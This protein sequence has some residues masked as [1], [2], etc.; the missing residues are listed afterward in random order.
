MAESLENKII[1]LTTSVLENTDLF[2]VDLELK[3]HKGSRTL[4]VYVDS[5]KGGVNLDECAKISEELGFLLDAHDVIAGHY[6][7]NVSSPGLDKPL[8]DKRQYFNKIGRNASITYNV[9]Q[10]QKKVKGEIKDFT[11]DQLLL[12]KKDGGTETIFFDDIIETK[13]LT[14]W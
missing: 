11:G 8:K 7:L 5:E 1:E 13:I 9:N 12:E 4:W 6:R 14:A 3:G 10:E 2:L